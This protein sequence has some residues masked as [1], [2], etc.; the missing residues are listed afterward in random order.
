MAMT[1]RSALDELTFEWVRRFVIDSNSIEGKR[2]T[3]ILFDEENAVH[4]FL[5][6]ESL[7]THELRALVDVLEPGARVRTNEDDFIRVGS[8]VAPPGGPNML[9][10]V[11]EMLLAVQNNDA[12]P[13]MTY[14]AWQNLHPLTDCNGRSGRVLYAWQVIHWYG[15]IPRSSFLAEFHYETLAV[16]DKATGSKGWRGLVVK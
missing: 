8:H 10:Q 1:K 5:N 13:I 2:H 11:V 6:A 16:F 14:M 15:R 7:G 3:G 12:N 4:A 9:I